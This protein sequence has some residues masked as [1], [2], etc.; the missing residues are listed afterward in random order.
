MPL[1]VAPVAK[2]FII[3]PVGSRPKVSAISRHGRPKAAVVRGP[4]NPANSS[5][6]G[7]K[8][9]SRS[10]CQVK[11]S[12]S[13]ARAPVGKRFEGRARGVA[14]RAQW[15]QSRAAP[16]QAGSANAS[17]SA[18]PADASPDCAGCRSSAAGCGAAGCSMTGMA[19]ALGCAIGSDETGSDE[20]RLRRCGGR[21]RLAIGLA[22]A[23]VAARSAR[24]C[25]AA[26]RT[27]WLPLGKSNREQPQVASPPGAAPNP[28]QALQP[29]G[30]VREQPACEPRDLPPVPVGRPEGF[31]GK[32]CGTG[33]AEQAGAGRIGPQDPPAVGRPQPCGQAAR[34]IGRQSGIAVRP[35]LKF[36]ILHRNYMTVRHQNRQPECRQR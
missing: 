32:G 33:R 22:S 10:I 21:L 2:A 3:R 13:G 27:P 30:A 7:V 36:R 5:V 20:D 29:D 19:G 31:F 28:L 14:A 24:C 34:R 18:N 9:L 6:P 17:N 1:Q 15:S 35:P 4:I 12:G 26:I 8:R 23:P 16:R 25:Q 11:R